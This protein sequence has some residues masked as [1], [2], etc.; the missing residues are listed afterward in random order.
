MIVVV[1]KAVGPQDPEPFV[2]IHADDAKIRFQY[3]SDIED[4]LF[5]EMEIRPIS[6]VHRDPEDTSDYLE[7]DWSN[8]IKK[9]VEKDI[10][11]GSKVDV[12]RDYQNGQIVFQFSGFSG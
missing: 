9:F 6:I 7:G 2:Q 12:Y 10:Q 4:L 1:N 5:H 3:L 11:W 8:I